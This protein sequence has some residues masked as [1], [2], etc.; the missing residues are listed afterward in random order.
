MGKFS[1]QVK[2]G[3]LDGLTSVTLYAALFVGDPAG[4]GVEISGGDYARKS[5]VTGYW[6]GASNGF[7][8]NATAVTFPRANGVWSAANI[9]HFALFDAATAGNLKASDDLPVAQQ[10]P[11][12]DGN[13]VEF[14]A[15]DID[16][17]ISDPA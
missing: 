2:N 1:V 16:L 13:T 15:G 7:K 4:A 14:A 10:Q 6:S 8:H 12:V 3:W 9:T 11:I 5:I 17:S